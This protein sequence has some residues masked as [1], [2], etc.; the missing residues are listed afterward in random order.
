MLR[1][2]L[3]SS[4]SFHEPYPPPRREGRSRLP[5]RRLVVRVPGVFPVD[6]PRPEIQLPLRPPAD[7]GGAAV[8]H[9]IVSVHPRGRDRH[10][11]DASR[12]HLRQI[13]GFVPARA[14]PALQI[15]PQ[16][17]AG[18]PHPAIPADAGG[19]ARLR[20]RPGRAEFLGGR[21]SHRDLRLHRQGAR[22]RCPY[23][24]CRQGFDAADRA[25]HR[26]VRSGLRHCRP[27]GLARRAPHHRRRGLCLFRRRPGPGDRRA[28][29]CRQ[30]H[31]Q[32]SRRARHRRENRGAAHHR[33]R[34]S[35][36][37]ACTCARDQTTEAA[38]DTDCAGFRRA[39]PAIEKA[40]D[41]L[42]GSA[43]RDPPRRS[44]PAGS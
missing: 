39:D 36:C 24:L 21:R 25:G 41:A 11:T 37:A 18:R 14:L 27:G 34:R 31:R 44:R 42:Q 7:R 28:G 32:H 23:H 19:G 4:R 26:D 3:P 2:S 8:L 35:R 40:G 1:V 10:Q 30:F 43:S 38:R 13:R 22:S 5:C 29:A 6:P 12:H 16:R 15:E 20:P 33:V 9:K 17:A